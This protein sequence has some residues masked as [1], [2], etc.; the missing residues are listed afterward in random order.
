[1]KKQRKLVFLPL[2]CLMLS[3]CTQEALAQQ[4]YNFKFASVF[5]SP[6][7]SMLGELAKLWQDEVTKRTN[8]AITFT[9][10][11]GC[12]LGTPPEHIEL[13]I[14]NVCQAVQTHQWY[15][16]SKMP[17]GDF[18]YT[19]L[20]GPT[21]Y[22]L[23]VKAMQK[24]RSEFPELAKELADNNAVMVMDAPMALY[25]FQCPTPIKSLDD[26]RDK[27][28][29]AVGRYFGQQMP[30][31][32]TVVIRPGQEYY[33]LIRNRICTMNLTPWNLT[34]AFKLQEVTKYFIE[35]G[36][37]TVCG[38]P[39]LMNLKTYNSLPPEY[40]KIVREAGLKM[41]MVAATETLPKWKEICYKAFREAGME[42]VTLSDEDKKKWVE[43]VEDIVD[44]W[45]K[46]VEKLG[47][48][49]YKIAHRWQQ[50]TEELGFKWPRKWAG[51]K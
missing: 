51:Y 37:V 27:K 13:L 23:V 34:Y 5:P 7:T 40:Q 26:F 24:I 2:V 25:D 35:T 22:P 28:I 1:M 19:F 12:A 18:E 42:I 45:A 4:K 15:T 38:T 30:K 29:C 11:W 44:V 32:A 46:D 48:P 39:V 50:I 43:E 3:V 9:N 31:G 14:G 41:E 8:G 36:L 47:L 49:G 21:D 33:D 20:F 17:L 6:E 16:P 10:H